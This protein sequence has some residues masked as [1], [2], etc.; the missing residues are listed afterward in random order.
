VFRLAGVFDGASLMIDAARKI[1]P[2][3]PGV[4][5]EAMLLETV[6]LDESTT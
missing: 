5:E 6:A 3:D 2:G 1:A 4:A